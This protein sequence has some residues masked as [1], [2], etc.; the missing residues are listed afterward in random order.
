MSAVDREKGVMVIKPSGVEYDTM[1]PEDMVA[2]SLATGE[3]EEG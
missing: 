2:V 3:K 1:T